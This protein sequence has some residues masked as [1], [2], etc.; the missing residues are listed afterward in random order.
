LAKEK[1]SAIWLENSAFFTLLDFSCIL[2]Y[3]QNVA[4]LGIY[5][6]KKLSASRVL[7][8]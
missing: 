1:K 6:V 2:S 4:I 8:P 5:G 7:V 3:L